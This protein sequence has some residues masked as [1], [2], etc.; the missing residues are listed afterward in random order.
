MEIYVADYTFRP[1]ILI[2]HYE[3]LVWTERFSAAGDFQLVCKYDYYLNNLQFA[4]YL[5]SSET[6]SIMMIE[7][8]EMD[9]Q[10]KKKNLVRVTGRSVEAF[11]ENRN[12][13]NAAFK[14][15]E[16]FSGTM[17]AI[18]RWIVFK[19]CVNSASAG[20]VNVIAPLRVADVIV[21]DLPTI[22]VEIERG[23]IYSIVKKLCDSEGLGF[24][25]QR[26]DSLWVFYVY[27]GIDRSD[28]N[29]SYYRVYSPDAENFLNT[30]YMESTRTWKNHTRVL[31]NKT[32]V[33]VYAP[34]TDPTVSGLDRR[35]LVIEA[36]DV[37][38]A[39]DETDPEKITTV[40]QD[41]K[42]LKAMGKA[43]LQE[44][45]NRYIRLVNGEVPPN[46]WSSISYGLGDIV[47]V[48]D[49]LGNTQK[50]R[51]TEQIFSSD[52]TGEKRTP[53]FDTP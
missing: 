51:I 36:S 12:N 17:A 42:I 31:G 28:K 7:D 29:T 13:K 20:A 9:T 2:D 11:L 33:D 50:M 48:R 16:G 39:A 44:P 27:D 5:L 53:S 23:D 46:K 14:D 35:T 43:A 15:P 22:D 47:M 26:E 19:Y 45:S 25:I 6:S 49:A 18:V 24:N 52:A 10:L 37:G 4:Q 30:G 8:V 32:G 40:A 21:D 3:S 38:S 41:Q 34:G 1:S